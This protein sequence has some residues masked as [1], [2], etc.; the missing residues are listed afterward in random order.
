MLLVSTLTMLLAMIDVF[1]RDIRY[2]LNNVFT[3]WFFLAPIVYTQRMTEEHLLLARAD[4]PDGL[5]HR[6]SSATSSTGAARRASP[7]SSACRWSAWPCSSLG[8]A[9]FRRTTVGLAKYV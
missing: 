7:P 3:V 4:R 8:L 2:V 5:G 6:P 1:N 9:V